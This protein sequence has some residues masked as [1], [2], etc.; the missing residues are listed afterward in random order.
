MER[1]ELVQ[2]L[3]DLKIEDTRR[4][5]ESIV[6][7]TK[8]K[9]AMILKRTSTLIERQRKILEQNSGDDDKLS[10]TIN[11]NVGGKKMTV[12]RSLLTCLKGSRLEVL[13]SERFENKILH[14]KEDHVFLDIDPDIFKR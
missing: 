13:L 1:Y 8:R 10:S 12:S 6:A 14:D 4:K 3:T 9:R 5:F 7:S 11:L 2:G